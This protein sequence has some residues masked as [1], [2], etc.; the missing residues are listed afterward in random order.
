MIFT[1]GGILHEIIFLRFLKSTSLAFPDNPEKQQS[2]EFHKL[3]DREVMAKQFIKTQWEGCDMM[4]MLKSTESTY[5]TG[6]L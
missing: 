3:E 4:A 5:Y 6:F 2:L 1:W